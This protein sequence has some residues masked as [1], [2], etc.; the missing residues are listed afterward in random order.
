M[1]KHKSITPYTDE[2]RI[3]YATLC[4][5][6]IVFFAYVYSISSAVAH[7]VMRK[8]IDTNIS[9]LSASVSKLEAEYI[10]LQHSVSSDIA[11]MKGFVAVDKKIFIDTSADTLVLSQN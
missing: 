5:F 11:T 2:S 6:S 8:E 10:E 7:V 3:F 9:E 1:K 4:I